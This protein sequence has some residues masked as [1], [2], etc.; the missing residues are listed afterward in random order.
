MSHVQGLSRNDLS[1]LVDRFV[2]VF[3]VNDLDAVMRHFTSNARYVTFD[4]H[5]H[6]GQSQIRAAFV[7]QFRGDFGQM[8]FAVENRII[9]EES[10]S[11][12]VLWTCRH[13]LSQAIDF[14]KLPAARSLL[15]RGV[16]GKVYS[17]QGLD[18]LSFEGNLVREKRTYSQAHMPLGRGER[19]SSV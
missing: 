6:R 4:G 18:V 19:W 13:E 3:N 16:Y 2:D 14:R 7:P 10:Q 5:E 17:W 1:V 11:A 15:V 12:V 8:H 9:D